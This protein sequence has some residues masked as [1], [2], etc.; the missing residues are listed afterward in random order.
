MF[1]YHWCTAQTW[2]LCH[3][4]LKVYSWILDL[5]YL[6]ITAKPQYLV[7]CMLWIKTAVGEKMLALNRNAADLLWIK[8]LLFLT[9]TLL[10]WRIW[11]APNNASRWQMGFNLVFKG[12]NCNYWL[13]RISDL[14]KLI[15]RRG[16]ENFW[17]NVRRELSTPKQ[18]TNLYEYMSAKAQFSTAPTFAWP[19]S[20]IFL[21]V[22]T[23]KLVIVFDS[24]LKRT[25]RWTTHF[26]CLSNRD[27]AGTLESL[28]HWHQ[29]Y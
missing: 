20:S 26:L 2:R 6:N 18:E 23:Y 13:S 1:N 4:L 19:Q 9:L 24:S 29:Y 7:G 25:E 8:R 12:L 17:K 3:V 5:Y 21:S 14:I 27:G 16:V 22:G 10:M 15:L 28:Q 11:W